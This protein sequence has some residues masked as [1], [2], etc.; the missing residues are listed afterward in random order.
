MKIIVLQAAIGFGLFL[1]CLLF[2]IVFL[3]WLLIKKIKRLRD[4]KVKDPAL[5]KG[6]LVIEIPVIIIVIL[7]LVYL[8][9]N[10]IFSKEPVLN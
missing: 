2:G 7:Y 9:V 1:P 10:L 6:M 8:L 5:Y 3:S 4:L